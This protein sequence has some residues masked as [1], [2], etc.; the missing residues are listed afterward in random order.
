MCACID[1]IVVRISPQPEQFFPLSLCH[2]IHL[3]KEYKE[4]WL[5]VHLQTRARSPARSYRLTNFMFFQQTFFASVT[6]AAPT[7]APPHTGCTHRLL[8]S[9][10]STDPNEKLDGFGFAQ[11]A[12][13]KAWKAKLYNDLNDAA[14]DKKRLPLPLLCYICI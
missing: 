5:S 14:D 7:P 8:H 3:A 9:A 2:C 12:Y 13:T 6:T 4:C 10:H 11:M 1:T